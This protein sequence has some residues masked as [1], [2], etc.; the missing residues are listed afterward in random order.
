MITAAQ[1]RQILGEFQRSYRNY[2]QAEKDND[3]YC[4]NHYSAK[5]IQLETICEILFIYR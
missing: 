3:K 1:K 4:S 2:L 5:F